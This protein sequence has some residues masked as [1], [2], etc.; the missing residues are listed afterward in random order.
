[1]GLLGGLPRPPVLTFFGEQ[2]GMELAL[3]ESKL[4][5]TKDGKVS[6]VSPLLLLGLCVMEHGAGWFWIS[7]WGP[8]RWARVGNAHLDVYATLHGAVPEREQAHRHQG[9]QGGSSLAV[10]CQWDLFCMRLLL[11]EGKLTGLRMARCPGCLVL[12]CKASG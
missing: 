9:R 8:G 2:G 6:P 4:T 5:V 11:D 7:C 3:G 10:S 1:M 12:R